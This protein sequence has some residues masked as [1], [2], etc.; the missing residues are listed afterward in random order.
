MD[1]KTEKGQVLVEGLF[2]MIF[3]VSILVVLMNFIKKQNGVFKKYEIPA[4]LQYQ[5]R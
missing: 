2:V 5:N 3:L 4:K 1:R